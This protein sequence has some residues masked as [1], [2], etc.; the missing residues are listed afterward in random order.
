MAPDKN[1]AEIV[2]AFALVAN[3]LPAVD[4]VLVGDGPERKALERLAAGD[5]HQEKEHEEVEKAK[6]G[7]EVGMKV[8]ERVREG[9]RVYKQ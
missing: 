3:A 5:L 9:Y 8:N 2:R 7:D 6:K 1:A 4:L